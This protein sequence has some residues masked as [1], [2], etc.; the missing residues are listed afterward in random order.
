MELTGSARGEDSTGAGCDAYL[1]VVGERLHV[2]V[3]V[4]VEGGDGE[5]ENSIEHDLYSCVR[6]PSTRR[7]MLSGLPSAIAD[8]SRSAGTSW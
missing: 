6:L 5:E 8:G 7:Q 4:C 2:D 1:D 3:A